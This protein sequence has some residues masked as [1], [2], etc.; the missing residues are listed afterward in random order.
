MGSG[1]ERASNTTTV[2]FPDSVTDEGGLIDKATHGT[3]ADLLGDTGADVVL[4]DADGN[5]VS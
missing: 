2:V 4:I 5:Q 1:V 3:V